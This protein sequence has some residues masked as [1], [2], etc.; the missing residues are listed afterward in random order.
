MFGVILLGIPN[1]ECH[2]QNEKKVFAQT[3]FMQ[4]SLYKPSY[5]IAT[6]SNIQHPN[7]RPQRVV[8]VGHH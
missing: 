6:T 5:T 2:T 8:F 3:G 1:G 7:I 4:C